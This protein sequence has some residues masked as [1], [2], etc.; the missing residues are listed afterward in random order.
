MRKK[1][2]TL[3]EILIV[4]VIFGVGILAIL[5]IMANSVKNFDTINMQ[6]RATLLAKEGIDLAF[7]H[8][9]SNLEQGYPRDYYARIENTD[10]GKEE[11]LGKDGNTTFKIGLSVDKNQNPYYLLE[12]IKI[13]EYTAD[14]FDEYFK[15]FALELTKNNTLTPYTYKATTETLN[16]GYARRIEFVRLKI[17]NLKLLKVSSHVIYKRGSF[18]GEVVLE[19]FLGPRDSER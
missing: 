8:R 10:G 17:E 15:T 13:G 7:H 2:F 11:F 4:I 18:T 19:S 14:T 9:D 5:S 6:T 3:I 16:K 1:A 12:K